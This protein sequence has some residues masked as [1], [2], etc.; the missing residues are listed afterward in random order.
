MAADISTN[1]NTRA[2]NVAIVTGDEALR[3]MLTVW[4]EDA[5]YS[6]VHPQASLD[7]DA[8]SVVYVA[9]TTPDS[10]S[11]ALVLPFGLRVTHGAEPALFLP[12]PV[13]R[14]DFIASLASLGGASAAIIRLDSYR[15]SVYVGGASI[16]LTGKEYAV[17]SFLFSRR[18]EPVS[19]EEITSAAHLGSSGTNTADVYVCRLRK[20]LYPL[21]GSRTIVTVRG[22]GYMLAV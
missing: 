20:K 12:R 8:D 9:D 17:M 11:A 19:R 13:S 3:G 15:K 7:A 2:H 4:L 14:A 5:G 18:G 6:V 16:P 22:K 21:L 1:A 10:T